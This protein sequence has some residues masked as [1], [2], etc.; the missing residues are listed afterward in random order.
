VSGQTYVAHCEVCRFGLT[1]YNYLPQRR[2]CVWPKNAR[3]PLV[4]RYPLFCYLLVP[5][6][7]SRDRAFGF[8]RGVKG[9]RWLLEDDE[10]RPWSIDDSAVR[11]LAQL[12]N[13]GAFSDDLAGLGGCEYLAA[14]AGQALAGQFALLFPEPP[15]PVPRAPTQ[16]ELLAPAPVSVASW[17]NPLKVSAAAARDVAERPSIRLDDRTAAERSAHASR[18]R[19]VALVNQRLN[20]RPVRWVYSRT[21]SPAG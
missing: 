15:S 12:E 10:G 18:A 21:A 13:A 16:A 4:R 7:Q 19:G 17:V 20:H 6:P 9:P 14:V 3:E 8:A 2:R 1:C 5:M 11:A